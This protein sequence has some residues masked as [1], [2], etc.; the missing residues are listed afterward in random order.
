METSGSIYDALD[1]LVKSKD[2][3]EE[4]TIYL[5]KGFEKELNSMSKYKDIDIVYVI[6]MAN[7]QML[8]GEK[9]FID[10]GLA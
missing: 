6:A 1:F 10:D 7:N 8:I 4:P 9:C 5:W 2:R 3:Y